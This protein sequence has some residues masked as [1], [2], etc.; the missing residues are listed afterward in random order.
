MAELQDVGVQSDLS[1]EVRDHRPLIHLLHLGREVTLR[2]PGRAEAE[3]IGQLDLLEEVLEHHPLARHIAVHLG[4]A[5][6]EEDVE[7]HGG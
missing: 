7:F 2:D 3:P 5:D 4:L 6:G 1:D